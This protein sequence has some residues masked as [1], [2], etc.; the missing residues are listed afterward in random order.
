M[1]LPLGAD[2]A[3]GFESYP[4]SEI[5]NKYIYDGFLMFYL[6]ILLLLFFSL[7]GTSKEIHKGFNSVVLKDCK[8]NLKII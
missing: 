5:P 3:W 1:L 6:F 8:K 4:T 2:G 7:F